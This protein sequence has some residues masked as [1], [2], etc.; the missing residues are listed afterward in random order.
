MERDVYINSLRKSKFKI[1]PQRL[2]IIDFV[3]SHTPGHFTAEEIYNEIHGNEP[4]MTMAT[5]YNIMKVLQSSGRINSFEVNGL[6][7]FES[8]T[9]FHGNFVCVQCGK[10]FDVEMDSGSMMR[11]MEDSDYNVKEV[12]V[13]MKGTCKGCSDKTAN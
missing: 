9:D 5:V 7:W 6:T 3:L 2:R 8:N 1:T 13:I 11:Q 4:S 10:I 12:S